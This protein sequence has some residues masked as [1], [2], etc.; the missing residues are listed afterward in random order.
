MTTEYTK[1]CSRCRE[2]KSAIEFYQ[3]KTKSDG[4]HSACKE[5]IKASRRALYAAN[6]EKY[7]AAMRIYAASDKGKARRARIYRQL[8]EDVI[9]AYGGACACCGE[10][11]PNF[12]TV[13]HVG[14]WGA[15]HRREAGAGASNIYQWLKRE[16]YPQD[17]RIQLLCWNC[18][19][20]LGVYGACPHM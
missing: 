15:E 10:D 20:T 17:G 5:C 13:D 14:G 7:K 2:T 3:D 9:A 4:L 6:P 16:G 8:R 1:P 11:E 19:C 18:N 12:L